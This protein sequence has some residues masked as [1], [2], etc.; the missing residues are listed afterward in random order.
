M[1]RHNAYLICKIAQDGIAHR[2]D[3]RRM[4]EQVAAERRNAAALR[5]S[6]GAAV[7]E[8]EDALRIAVGRIH[9]ANDLLRQQRAELEEAKARIAEL[10]ARVHSWKALC[11]FLKDLMIKSGVDSLIRIFDK[12]IRANDGEMINLPS[13]VL[14]EAFNAKYAEVKG[15]E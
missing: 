15:R 9:E 1:A 11:S 2:R 4:E 12:N 7:N 8:T 13:Q 10:E 6:T 5:T 14:E 3:M